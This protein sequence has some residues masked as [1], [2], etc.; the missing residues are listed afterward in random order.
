[1]LVTA[2]GA[3]PAAGQSEPG[4][5]NRV[6]LRV[7][8]RIVTLYE[9][10]RAVA[11][12]I[13]D[14][15]NAP[16]LTDLRRQELLGESGRINIERVPQSDAPDPD[17]GLGVVLLDGAQTIREVL[18]HLCGSLHQ[19]VLLDHVEGGNRRRAGDRIAPERCQV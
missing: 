7:N 4:R 10:Q 5:E 19:T 9:Y 3:M 17:Q 6:V 12:Q 2:L 1:M 15:R 14:I 11:V 18:P 13:R 16:G 8:D